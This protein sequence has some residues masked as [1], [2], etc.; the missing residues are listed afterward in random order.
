MSVFIYFKNREIEESISL[1][2]GSLSIMET[3]QV[4]DFV[5]KEKEELINEFLIKV[6]YSSISLEKLFIIELN[7]FKFF[8]II[9]KSLTLLGGMV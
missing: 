3:F 8:Y 7:F 1:N 9:W 2:F 4:K 6:I 5:T